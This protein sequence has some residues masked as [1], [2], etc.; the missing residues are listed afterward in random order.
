MKFTSGANLSY[1]S[2]KITG[3]FPTANN[4]RINDFFLTKFFVILE[5]TGTKP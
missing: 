5:G 3:T 1:F 4:I 2:K